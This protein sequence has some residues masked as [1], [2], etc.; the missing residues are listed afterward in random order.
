MHFAVSI[1]TI[2]WMDFGLIGSH[3][4]YTPYIF[5]L[6]VYGIAQS[7]ALF[8]T[9]KKVYWCITAWQRL[10]GALLASVVWTGAYGYGFGVC[11]GSF[12]GAYSKRTL[13]ITMWQYPNRGF[14]FVFTFRYH[15][16]PLC[17]IL[18]C[19]WQEHVQFFRAHTVKF[20]RIL[21]R[22]LNYYVESRKCDSRQ[23]TSPVDAGVRKLCCNYYC[24]VWRHT[25]WKIALVCLLGG[26]CVV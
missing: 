20:H 10:K 12:T 17:R 16:Q 26:I 14:F 11:T 25:K 2:G 7:A 19:T 21:Y 8:Q 23:S 18:P 5:L 1:G 13:Q 15:W 6:S 9:G 3:C 24:I 4:M 22:L